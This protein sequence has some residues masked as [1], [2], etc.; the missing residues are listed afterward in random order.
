M[1][2]H[3]YKMLD[4]FCTLLASCFMIYE[5]SI[6]ID[7]FLVGEFFPLFWLLQSSCISFKLL[8]CYSFHIWGDTGFTPAWLFQDFSV[9]A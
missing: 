8:L 6:I 1:K 2:P 5:L 3:I 7:I 4:Y 9:T